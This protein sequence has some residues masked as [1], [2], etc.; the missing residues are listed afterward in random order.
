MQEE[1]SL[2]DVLAELKF[3]K[4]DIK[5]YANNKIVYIQLDV[6][7]DKSNLAFT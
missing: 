2:S 5:E 4:E 7:N 1:P 6:Y 3:Q